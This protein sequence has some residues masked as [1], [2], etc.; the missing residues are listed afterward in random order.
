M[1]LSAPVYHLKRRAKALARFENIPLH[2]A[3]DRIAREEGFA[4][5]SLLASRAM[6]GAC[7]APLLSRLGPGDVLLIGARPG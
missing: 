1:R 4:A 5:W 6:T 7:A 2:Q 3:L